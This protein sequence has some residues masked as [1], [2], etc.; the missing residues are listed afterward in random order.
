MWVF[1]ISTF[2]NRGKVNAM[3]S[4]C[5]YCVLNPRTLVAAFIVYSILCNAA[6]PIIEQILSFHS[7]HS[8]SLSRRLFCVSLGPL[9]RGIF[10]LKLLHKNWIHLDKSLATLQEPLTD[11]PKPIPL[12]VKQIIQTVNPERCGEAFLV[13]K[14]QEHSA[15]ELLEMILD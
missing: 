10:A 14:M 3:L 1:K 13:I 15:G 4:R 12:L 9:N 2:L 5:K 8:P 11:F 7:K 6:I